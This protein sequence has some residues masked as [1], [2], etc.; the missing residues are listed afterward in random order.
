MGFIFTSGDEKPVME[1][2]TSYLFIFCILVFPIHGIALTRQPDLRNGVFVPSR[3]GHAL[4]GYVFHQLLVGSAIRCGNACLMND[5]CQSYNYGNTADSDGKYICQLNNS[6]GG[7]NPSDLVVDE[8][9]S[10][11]EEPQLQP[12]Q[13]KIN[14]YE[15]LCQNEGTCK[16]TTE[17]YFDRCECSTYYTGKYCD[18]SKARDCKEILN[19]GGT[20]N[21]VYP[22]NPDGQGIIRV[23]C[24][25]T[26]DGGGWIV[27]QQRKTPFNANF[28]A[29]WTTYEE[30]FGNTSSEFWLGN[31]AIHRITKTPRQ[32]F[33]YLK[34]DQNEG[35]VKYYNF[36]VSD[37]SGNYRNQFDTVQQSLAAGNAMSDNKGREFSTFDRDNDS[38]QYTNCASIMKSGWWYDSSCGHSDLN[39]NLPLWDTWFD[40]LKLSECCMKVR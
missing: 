7:S 32:L 28:Y 2:R 20:S 38:N 22:I 3:P 30:G 13:V 36:T 8:G 23:L 17:G 18:D 1:A 11:Y 16:E 5:K 21:A 26:R 31:K 19:M 24:D 6:T 35:T 40:Y 12:N 9:F 15:G 4:K 10:Y 34:S 39:K 27:I 14:C 37:D 25:Q 33:I 29:N